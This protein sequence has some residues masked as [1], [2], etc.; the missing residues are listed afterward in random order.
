MFCSLLQHEIAVVPM[1]SMLYAFAQ[2]VSLP[3][4]PSP[5]LAHQTPVTPFRICLHA[6]FSRKLALSFT[7]NEFAT[8]RGAQKVLPYI[9]LL[10]HF[11]PLFFLPAS[12]YLLQ[13]PSF[14]SLCTRDPASSKMIEG[15]HSGKHSYST[16]IY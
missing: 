4:F 14:S 16:N 13:G 15:N 12:E 5:S 7:Q 1:L 3:G 6:I 10:L 2:A 8:H 9:P 11:L